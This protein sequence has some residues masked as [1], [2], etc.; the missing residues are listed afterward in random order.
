M[1]RCDRARLVPVTTVA[2][3]RGVLDATEL[4]FPARRV[5]VLHDLAAEASRGEHANR[6]THELI[7]CAVGAVTATVDEGDGERDVRLD[8]PAMALHLPPLVW[9]R[10]HDHAPG[11]VLIV[12]A[13]T[14]YDPDDAIRDRDEHR[15]LTSGG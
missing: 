6:T 14:P 2:D 3:E 5:F 13:S 12:A 15:R 11:T 10:L 4:P 1:N 9:V 8:S 7:V